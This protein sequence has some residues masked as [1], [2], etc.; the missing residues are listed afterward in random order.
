MSTLVKKKLS[1]KKTKKRFSLFANTDFIQLVPT[2]EPT[3]IRPF[4]IKLLKSGNESCQITFLGNPFI[5]PCLINPNHSLYQTFSERVSERS[6][7]FSTFTCRKGKGVDI[8]LSEGI[9]KMRGFEDLENQ[10]FLIKAVEGSVENNYQ[11]TLAISASNLWR[12]T[13][14]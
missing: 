6:I 14:Y 9:S 11:L 12:V 10:G 7:P 13:R 4:K 3:K 2:G 5:K 1:L 8:Y